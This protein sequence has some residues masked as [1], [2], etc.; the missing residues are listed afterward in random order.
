MKKLLSLLL[1]LTFVLSVVTISAS[2]QETEAEPQNVLRFDANTA[3]IMWKYPFEKVYC[4]IWEYGGEPFFNWQSINELCVDDAK[5]GIWTYNLDKHGV[6][7]EDGKVY[8]VIFSNE[9]G[10]STYD[11]IFDKTVL[12][13]TAYC[14]GEYY[15]SPEETLIYFAYWRNHESTLNGYGPVLHIS[16]IGNVVGKCI[17]ST[18]TAQ[19]MFDEM[20]NYKMDN[21][22]IYSGK[23]DQ[24][25]IDDLATEIEL[26]VADVLDSIDSTGKKVDWNWYDSTLEFGEFT[27]IIGDVDG[28]LT[29]SVIDATIIQQYKAG[30]TTIHEKLLEYG[31]VDNDTQVSVMDATQIQFMKAQ[32]T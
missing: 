24:D 30:I 15:D 6:V 17:P 5:D 21:A 7:L 28:D 29:L 13:D 14:N 26:T 4:H 22:R 1:V 2:A 11:M 20:L 23:E 16:S 8:G 18:T 25:I 3:A 31:D 19:K 27:P 9:N 10:K 12:G 32:L